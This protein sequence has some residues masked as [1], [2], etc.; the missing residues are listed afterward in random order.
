[1]RQRTAPTGEAMA[2]LHARVAA[3]GGT[4]TVWAVLFEDLYETRFGDGCYRYVRGIALNKEH[5]YRLAALGGNSELVAWHVRAYR[6]GLIRDLLCFIDEIP[7]RDSVTMDEFAEIMDE[8]T[9]DGVASRLLTGDGWQGRKPG[10]HMRGL[11]P[12]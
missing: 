8:I 11:G 6:I 7:D 4:L 3:A 10:P 2:A 12:C 1:M 9:P 5:A